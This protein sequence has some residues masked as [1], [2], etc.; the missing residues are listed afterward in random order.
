MR[1]TVASANGAAAIC[2]DSGRPSARLKP[3]GI[4]K[5]G[6]PPTLNGIV[7]LGVLA[8]RSGC[9]RVGAVGDAEGAGGDKGIDLA[10]RAG[11]LLDQRGAPA[12]RRHVVL[13]ADQRAGQ[14][15][16]AQDAAEI[17]R[18]RAQILLVDRVEF[19]AR[20]RC[21]A[22]GIVA[23]ARQLDRLD[24]RAEIAQHLDRRIHRGGEVG[25]PRRIGV[26]VFDHAEAHSLD[27]AVER[28]AVIRHRHI[29]AAGVF[30]V[31]AGDDLQEQRDVLGAAGQGAA[32]VHRKRVREDAAAADPAI[33]RL[34]PGE[35]AKR[36][37]TA[38]R[39]AGIGADRAGHKTRRHRRAGAAR[40]AARHVAGVPR[41]ARRWPRQVIARA[42]EREFPGGELAH[43]HATAG[44]EPLDDVGI[45]LRHM[46]LAQF[47]MPGGQ[48]AG[49][50]DDVL[51]RVG[52]AVHRAAALAS[53]Q[54]AL[55]LRRLGQR[56]VLGG[57]QKAVQFA[58]MRGDAR[59]QAFGDLDRRQ[60]ALAV[61]PAQFRNRQ[62]GDIH[63]L[64][65]GLPGLQATRGIQLLPIRARNVRA[66]AR[67]GR[68]V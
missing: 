28:G 23:Q 48:D 5:A 2:N 20:Y 18:S 14:D 59:E 21:L 6:V 12:L 22:V 64:S 55:S 43:Q 36:R 56:L 63:R 66:E 16:V 53:Q 58:V 37:R 54:F 46:V 49:G 42:A 60:F 3:Q 47:R 1:N 34:D 40:R 29:L 62:K 68:S 67:S 11:L 8:W 50:L 33:A 13:G 25:M 38:H 15:A 10:Q 44:V 41:V 26:P 61:K 35:V 65:S 32:M 9:I 51:Q 24:D 52:D 19:D 7:M 30:L 45:G 27:A 17:L 57:A 4:A 31:V 39:A